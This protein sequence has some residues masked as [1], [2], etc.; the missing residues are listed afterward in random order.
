MVIDSAPLTEVI[1]ALP[2]ARHADGVVIVVR[3]GQ[4]RLDKVAQLAELLAENEIKPV[5]FTIVNSP[6]LGGNQ[7]HY[8]QTPVAG[9][10]QQLPGGKRSG[11]R[12][13]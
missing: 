6:R 10:E 9:S 12:G 11:S 8:H 13:S 4:S 2:L 3:I 1:D 7:Y 5:G